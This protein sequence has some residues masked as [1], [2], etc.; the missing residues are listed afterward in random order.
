MSAVLTDVTTNVAMAG[1]LV[2]FSVGGSA[3]C[4]ARTNVTGRATCT[5]LVTTVRGALGLGYDATY[6]GEEDYLPAAGHGALLA[7]GTQHL[8]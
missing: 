6:A 1:R 3:V 8:P 7:I 4:E 2:R 5:G